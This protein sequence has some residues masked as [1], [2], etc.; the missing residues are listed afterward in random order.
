MEPVASQVGSTQ[1]QSSH[2]TCK[3]YSSCPHQHC[4]SLE[5]VSPDEEE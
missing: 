2:E 3:P 4:E 5:H 1:H